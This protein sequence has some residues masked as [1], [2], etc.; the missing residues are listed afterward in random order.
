MYSI[1][2]RQN[3]PWNC[4]LCL[5]RRLPQLDPVAFRVHDSG[6]A[7]VVVVFAFGIYFDAPFLQ[8]GQQYCHAVV[9]QIIGIA[10]WQETP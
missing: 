1:H 6:E 7:A 9:P 3:L 2:Q 4:G 8:R 5:L 10:P